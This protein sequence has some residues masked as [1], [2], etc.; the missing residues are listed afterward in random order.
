MTARAV[1]LRPGEES[2]AEQRAALDI[3]E[4]VVRAEDRERLG[5]APL[6]LHPLE[7]LDP[8]A[9]V[10]DLGDAR[11]ARRRR[12]SRA[13]AGCGPHT[14]DGR[15][16]A[17]SGRRTASRR[18]P[19]GPAISMALKIW[20]R[21]P[22]T[23][24]AIAI[25]VVTP[26]TTPRMVSADAELVRRAS[27]RAR[28]RHPR[29]R[30]GAHDAYSARSAVIGSSRAARVRGIDTERRCRLRRRAQAPRRPT[31]G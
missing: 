12:S 16:S 3:H 10:A 24:E 4:A 14:G 2:A 13:P 8:H 11:H 23:I 19:S 28:S 15:D 1:Q 6:V 17:G 26:I 22:C 25:T 27:R 18:T 9:G 20:V 31:R 29:R 30:S 7:Q 21:M 5:R